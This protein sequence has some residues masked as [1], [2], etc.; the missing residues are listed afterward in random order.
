[1]QTYLLHFVIIQIATKK[2]SRKKGSQ[3]K[4]V[5][6]QRLQ[7]LGTKNTRNQAIAQEKGRKKVQRPNPFISQRLQP[8]GTKNTRN[9]AIAQEKGR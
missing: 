4:P 6:S 2:N 1:V 7:P 9:Q 3:T 5:I 8:M